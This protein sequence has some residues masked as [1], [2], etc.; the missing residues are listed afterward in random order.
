[1]PRYYYFHKFICLA[2]YLPFFYAVGFSEAAFA[3]NV[4]VFSKSAGFRHVDAIPPGNDLFARM[5]QAKSW[6]MHF[7]EESTDFNEA[8]LKSTDVVVWNNVSGNALNNEQRVAF[9]QYLERGGG[10]VAIHNAMH[11]EMSWPY[12]AHM[13][14]TS[15]QGHGAG[16]DHIQKVEV[17]VE[18]RR[19]QTCRH[20]P[21][22][23]SRSDEWYNFTSNP[24]A[25]TQVLLSLNEATLTG[26]NMQGDHPITWTSESRGLRI[27]YTAFG[28]TAE[29]FA[30]PWVQ[31]MLY[32][33]V[34]WGARQDPE[35][36]LEE[37]NG[38]S[39]PGSWV[40]QSPFEGT[41][42]FEVSK[43]KLIMIGI[44]SPVANQQLTREGIEVDATRPYAMEAT[45]RITTTGGVQSFAMNFLQDN[46]QPSERIN[47]WTLNLDLN[48]DGTHG[49]I[50]YMGF[51]NGS[52]DAL[53]P[54][55]P[56]KWARS[57]TDYIYRIDVNRRLDGTI[58]PK[59]VTARISTLDGKVQDRFE[60]DYSKFR[61]QP[62]LTKPAH[63]G[64]NTH[65]ATWEARDLRVF[66]TDIPNL[67]SASNGQESGEN[68]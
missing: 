45:F 27:F 58:A 6:E 10:L 44:K 4:L 9:Q 68:P 66:Y 33:A 31:T 64:L 52:F 42:P 46:Q 37:F 18:N 40:I 2:F 24:R 17:V 51:N 62:D 20:F 48:G 22:T 41:F 56:A 35:L 12:Y 5:G 13:L 43:E 36:I 65:F 29:S 61:W 50:K 21:R 32:Q 34:L 28:H 11:A 26:P 14:G 23:F 57:D 7:S 3:L 16:K 1:M 39:E 25:H 63:I 15:F 55:R 30:E 8:R 54:S 38:T 60:V 49:V 47:S 59:W 67:A 19:H 53:G